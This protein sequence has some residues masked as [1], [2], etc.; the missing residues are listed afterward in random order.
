MVLEKFDAKKQPKLTSAELLGKLE[1]DLAAEISQTT[2]GE[3][4]FAFFD[5]LTVFISL[6]YCTSQEIH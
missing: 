2:P 5:I 4:H 1:Q 3:S 6:F